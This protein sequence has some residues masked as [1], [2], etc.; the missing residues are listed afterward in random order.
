M[1][2]E[3][4]RTVRASPALTYGAFEPISTEK[5]LLIYA[6][7]TDTLSVIVILNIGSDPVS[8]AFETIGSEAVIELS[9]LLDRSGETISRSLDL[10]GNEGTIVR[11]AS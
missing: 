9:T 10:R 1:D 3:S 7:R 6:R 5:D 11:V 2:G 4:S 8:V